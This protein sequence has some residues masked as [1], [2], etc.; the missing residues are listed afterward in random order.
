MEAF[1]V[2]TIAVGIAEIGDKSLFLAILLTMRYQQPWTVFMGLVAGI[3]ANLTIAAALGATLAQWL[4]GDWLAWALGLTFIAVAVWALV[5]EKVEHTRDELTTTSHRS[6]FVTAATGFFLLEMADKTQIATMALAA[7]F[8]TVLPVLAGA[9]LGVTL[10]NAP[11]IWLGN[12]F[13]ARLPLKTLR[14]VAA[15]LFALIGAWLLIDAALGEPLNNP[16]IITQYP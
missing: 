16:H 2:S 11:A 14:L 15:A 9:V 12:R 10:A 13:A 1:L 7:S 3:T 5:P 6:V 8:E 4:Q